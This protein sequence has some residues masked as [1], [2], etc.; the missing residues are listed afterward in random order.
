MNMT[1]QTP[2]QLRATAEAALKPLGTKRIKLLAQAKELET[3]LRPLVVQAVA[4]EVPYRKITE[5]TG[6]ASNTAR[7]W[8]VKDTQGS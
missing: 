2:A 8:W 4:M 6:V 1:Q 7:L 3:E 5:L